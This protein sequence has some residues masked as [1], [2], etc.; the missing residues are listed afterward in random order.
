MPKSNEEIN[1]GVILD[2]DSQNL[3][4]ENGKL[5]MDK[6]SL[7]ER[8]KQNDLLVKFIPFGYEIGKQTWQELEKNK[9]IIERYGKEGAEKIT[10]VISEYK[11]KSYIFSFN[12]VNKEAIKMS[13]LGGYWCFGD[14]LYI[15]GD[16]WSFYN[17]HYAF[18]I[19]GPEKE[20]K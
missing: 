18:G 17:K 12:S 7:I 9:Y 19:R 6:N 2:L 16:G 1:N 5:V 3:K 13:A 4:F 10:K 15:D 14:T 11:D 20:N 8:L